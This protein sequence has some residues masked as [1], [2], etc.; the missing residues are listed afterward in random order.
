MPPPTPQLDIQ[1]YQLCCDTALSKGYISEGWMCISPYLEVGAA[2][3]QTAYPHLER[4]DT[5]VWIGIWTAFMTALDDCY[6][7]LP[8]D[9]VTDFVLRMLSGE[10]QPNPNL[11]HFATHL[12]ELSQHVDGL[13]A[14]IILTSTFNWLASLQ[15]DGVM[16]D[17][18]ISSAAGQFPAWCSVLSGICEGYGVLAFPPEV[19][20][21]VI[22]PAIPDM[23]VTIRDWNDVFS[24]YKEERAGEVSTHICL[25]A[26]VEKQPKLVVLDAVADATIT[27]HQNICDTLSEHPGALEAWISFARGY[28]EFHFLSKRYRLGELRLH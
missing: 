2:I 13:R 27:A 7:H 16:L 26:Q 1:F 22:A 23:L 4:T 8:D 24:Y 25:L 11:E 21:H 12:R 3:A 19:P 14:A 6:V 17:K 18:M 5:R 10:R 9:A 20:F 15:I 28:V